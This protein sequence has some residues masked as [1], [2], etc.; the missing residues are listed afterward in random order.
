MKKQN[1]NVNF[2]KA[3][4]REPVDYTPVW[5]MR[6]AGRY[7]KEYQAIRS[8]VDFLTLCKTPQL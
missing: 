7:M 2:L 4:R 1:K 3:C 5:M 8:K 6:Q